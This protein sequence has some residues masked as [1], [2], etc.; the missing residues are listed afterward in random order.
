MAVSQPLATGQGTRVTIALPVGNSGEAKAAIFSLNTILSTFGT[1][2]H[3]LL[4]PASF[5]FKRLN[6][7]TGR[8][9]LKE[10][11][12]VDVV[13]SYQMNDASFLKK[14]LIVKRAIQAEYR[15]YCGSPPSG[16]TAAERWRW[17]TLYGGNI[18]R[19][20]ITPFP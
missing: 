1:A 11:C 17:L 2:T 8:I 10:I 16:A 3:S 19:T 20:S 7:G 5:E 18:I 4:Q 9:E 6:R 13:T 14:L 15:R 12:L